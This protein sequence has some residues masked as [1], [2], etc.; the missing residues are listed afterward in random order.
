MNTNP[1]PTPNQNVFEVSSE[2][3]GEPGEFLTVRASSPGPVKYKSV[4]PGL[5]VFP[6]DQLRDN[7]STVVVAKDKG[8][9]RLLAWS[10]VDG[11]PTDG[12]TCVV[13]IGT[14]KKPFSFAL[15]AWAKWIGVEVMVLAAVAAVV[16]LI[17]SHPPHAPIPPGP[18][19]PPPPVPGNLS[20]WV[21]AVTDKTAPTP[22]LTNLL[23]SPTLRKSLADA[24]HTFRWYDQKQDQVTKL[25]LD[26]QVAK[27]GGVP[28]LILLEKGGPNDGKV[29]L[30]ARVPSSEQT[31]LAAIH[32]VG[33]K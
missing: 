17:A 6:A 20:F 9:Y 26:K 4:D 16:W 19:P 3:T 18:K 25:G 22:E 28:A 14:P 23:N 1:N 15:P 32:S 8:I 7:K 33:G 27:A 21:V 11:A 5:S 24:G 2:L 10:V 29:H 31:F 13:K 30:A 12:K